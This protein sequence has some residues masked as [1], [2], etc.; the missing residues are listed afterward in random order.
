MVVKNIL[1]RLPVRRG[2]LHIPRVTFTDPELAQVGLREAEARAAHGDGAV[3]VLRWTFEENDRA[4]TERRTA[5]LIKVV[6][7][8]GGRIL[9]AGIAGAQAGELIGTW[10]L[11][12]SS[13]LKIRHM[14]KAVMPYP[15]FGEIN[16]RAAI[17]YYTGHATKPWLRSVISLMA[18]FG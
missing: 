2:M 8:K 10:A 12:I 18:R 6:I 16:K 1:L 3:S 4:Q 13:G 14:A 9:G 5:G 17:C 15:T 11:A 7:G